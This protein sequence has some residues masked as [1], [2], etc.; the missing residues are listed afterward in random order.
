MSFSTANDTKFILIS[1]CW[2]SPFN[3]Q[4]NFF[5]KHIQKILKYVKL[6]T[7]C[8]SQ[9]WPYNL[10]L[11]QFFNG[12][13]TELLGLMRVFIYHKIITKLKTSYYTSN[14]IDMKKN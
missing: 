7:L 8:K 3:S 12:I 13:L 1:F 11:K 9:K 5:Q 2:L 14:Y 10:L 4:T 6:E